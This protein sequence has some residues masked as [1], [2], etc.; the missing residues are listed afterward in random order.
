MIKD[1]TGLLHQINSRSG[2]SFPYAQEITR[3]WGAVDAVVD[4]CKSECISDWR[5]Q[6]VE[7]TNVNNPGRYIFYFDSDRDY[8]AFVMKWA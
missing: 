2:E 4:W 5:W 8:L 7:P 6:I 1:S 3:T